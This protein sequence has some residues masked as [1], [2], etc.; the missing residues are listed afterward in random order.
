MPSPPSI[1][2]VMGIMSL[3]AAIFMDSTLVPVTNRALNRGDIKNG[4]LQV[5]PYEGELDEESFADRL[6][7][8]SPETLIEKFKQAA[9]VGVTHISNWMNFGGIEHEK[10]MRSIRLMGEEVLP[11]LRDIHPPKGL[12]KELAN[13]P[14][15]TTEERQRLRYSGPSVTR[16]I[17]T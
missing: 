16:N 12:A 2:E 3:S 14:D 1:P 6:Y 7:F 13:E 17:A 11:A 4:Q 10:L 5:G 15:M 8:G 9:E